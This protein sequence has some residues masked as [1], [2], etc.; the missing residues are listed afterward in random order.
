MPSLT[1]CVLWSVQPVVLLRTNSVLVVHVCDIEGVWT[2]RYS[3][4]SATQTAADLSA[5]V[6]PHQCHDLRLVQL[7]GSHKSRSLVHGNEL[8]RS[9]LHVHLLRSTRNAVPR[10]T[11]GQQVYHE[12]PDQ[13]DDNGSHHQRLD[14]PREDAGWSLLPAV[15]R[16]HEIWLTD[17]SELFLSVYVFLL[18]HI[19]AEEA[20]SKQWWEEETCSRHST[21]NDKKF[22]VMLCVLDCAKFDRICYIFPLCC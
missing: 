14:L 16:E 3:I 5:L 6:S 19:L 7:H 18:C 9:F 21:G 10:R 15:I 20:A 2:W 11:L 8:H 12:H 22:Y 1:C 17:V 4:H 13:P